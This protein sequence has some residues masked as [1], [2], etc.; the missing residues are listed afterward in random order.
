VT[1]VN[2]SAPGNP[3][4]GY[5]SPPVP[6]FG[7]PGAGAV[8]SFTMAPVYRVAGVT[9]TNFGAGYTGPVN[10][11]FS[12]TA[13]GGAAGTVQ[14]QSTRGVTGVII[15]TPGSGYTSAPTITI[16]SASGSGAVAGTV[17]TG[18]TFVISSISVLNAGSG[19]TSV[20][21]ITGLSGTGSGSGATFGPFTPLP[22]VAQPANRPWDG[23]S[24]ANVDTAYFTTDYLPDPGSPLATGADATIKYPNLTTT[25]RNYPKFKNRT[26]CVYSTSYCTATEE[27]QNYANWKL[28]HS[29]RIDLAMTGLG[30]AFQPLNPTFRLGWSTINNLYNSKTLDSGVQRYDSSTQKAFMDWLYKRTSSPNNFTPN[31]FALDRVG[32]YYQR[33]DD[34]GPWADTPS[35]SSTSISA[36]G[37]V[38]THASCRR[39]YSIL[40]TD[41]YY[42]DES[43]L[44]TNFSI[45]DFDSKASGALNPSFQ[46]KPVGP[47]SDTKGGTAFSN[48]FADVA[49]KYWLSDLRK[50]VTNGIKP[51]PGDEANWQHMNFYAIGLGLVGTLDAN[52]PATLQGLTGD[53]INNPKRT[54]DWPSPQANKPEAIDDM[55]HATINGRGKMLNA[56]TA[57][58]LNTAILQMMADING[59]EATQSGVAVST[60]SLTQGTK[61]YTPSYTSLTWNGNVTAYN[62][63]E[64]TGDQAGIA[65]QVEKE[66]STDPNTG[67]K[68][69]QSSMPAA[70]VR[71][72]F[73]GNGAVTG[74]PRAVEFKYDSMGTLLGSMTGTV[75]KD[76]INYL[77][78]D[79][80]KEHTSTSESDPSAIFRARATRLGDIVNSTPVFVKSSTDLNYNKLP[81]ASPFPV[82]NGYRD[83]VDGTGAANAKTGGKA[84]RAEGV[85][86]VGANDGMLHAFRDGNATD[87]GGVEVFAYVPNA[88]LPTLNQLTDE[89]YVHRYYVDGPN[90]ETDAYIGGAWKNIILG[91]T[92]AGAGKVGVA[93]VS[94]PRTAVYAIDVTSLNTSVTGLG[95]SNVMWEISS[96]QANFAELGYVLTD[97]QA[98]P[99]MSSS[100]PWIAVVNNGYDSKSCKAMLYV[101]NLATGAR[102]RQIDTGVGAC[103][104]S[105]TKNGLGGVRIVRDGNQRIIG[106]YAGDLQG[107]LWKFD[108]SS[109]DSTTW[110]A[111]VL[112]KAGAAKPFTAQPAILPLTDLTVPSTGYMVV[113][114]TGKFFEVSD[115]NTT[116]QQ[117]LYGVWDSVPF[118]STAT[119]V[120]VDLP[121]DIAKMQ[122]QTIGTSTTIGG[123]T[124]AEISENDFSYTGAS[125]K[126]GWY[127]DYVKTGQR[128][129]YP[130]DLLAD[131]FVAADTISPSNVSA[132]PCINQGAGSSF[133]YIVD[134]I[135]GKRPVDQ[136]FDTNGDGSVNDK[137]LVVSGMEGRADGRN[138]TLLLEKTALETKLVNVSGGDPGGTLIKFTCTALGNCPNPVTNTIK[139]RTWRQ[140][141]MR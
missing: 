63:N 6:T 9:M 26:D 91:T 38:T 14:T 61:K 122:V 16:N 2:F 93:T 73:V 54:L 59:K 56:K 55:W 17:N 115:I 141:F 36:S 64:K 51:V 69:Y 127:M 65:W 75:T 131:K 104:T 27:F 50:N 114:G 3:G 130:I 53:L 138:V 76:M 47:Y 44:S 22:I 90:T 52:D 72:I 134:A 20:P 10:V 86:F 116:T 119:L 11:N 109:T 46:Y 140:L 41:G 80:T 105:A 88:L 137:D 8:L 7:G 35:A 92:G 106:A 96:N 133:L 85:L 139:S 71:N 62:L 25:G 60:A 5:S 37:D 58:E 125:A 84:Q 1:G 57:K 34:S 101:I 95:A 120:V 89:A 48:S 28:Y 79:A 18:T 136:I 33:G 67:V 19:Y 97:V 39:S 24:A 124:F 68:T 42:N 13:G 74:T 66:I 70:D 112:L 110:K 83:F 40:M 49:M 121:T 45:A 118:G 29:T 21:T 30:L 132:D 31:R 94:S 135:T 43:P 100:D 87:P 4:I 117:T 113:A 111:T 128:L 129:V 103:T 108:L 107:N 98:G 32:Q 81:A 123:K 82:P 23:T 78:G 99:S 12:S 15:N 126:R 102:V 77:R